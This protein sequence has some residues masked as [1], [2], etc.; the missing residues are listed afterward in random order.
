MVRLTNFKFRE[1]LRIAQM[2]FCTLQFPLSNL[3]VKNQATLGL[4]TAEPL[5]YPR[6]YGE[7]VGIFGLAGNCFKFP[8]D[9]A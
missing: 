3:I 4:I 6:N 8:M 5:R 7:R 1:M 9:L 2:Q